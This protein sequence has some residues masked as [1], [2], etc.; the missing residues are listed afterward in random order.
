MKKKLKKALFILFLLIIFLTSGLLILDNFILPSYVSE[1]EIA[2]PDVIGLH[3]DEAIEILKTKNLN[4]VLIG[5]RYDEKFKADEIMFQK[6]A[7]ANI[8]KKNRRI[9]LHVSGGEALI[10]IPDVVGKTFRDAKVSLERKGIYVRQ[11][12]Q[13]KSDLPRNT[14][15]AQEFQEGS[16]L[17]R[18]DSITLSVSVGPSI[19]MIRVPNI[20]AKSL[21][22]ADRTLR[23]NNLIL[24]NVSYITSPTLLT[25]TI[26]SQYPSENSLLNV[27]DSVDVVVAKS[28][29]NPN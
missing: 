10:K 9:Y 24:G 12:E 7:G 25:N 8:V 20:I 19:G 15:I 3:K 28:K 2:V 11:V 4:P 1:E 16:S 26:V 23:I 21:K 22:E 5:P 6:P 29:I 17:S 27:G 13:V 14:V 18:G